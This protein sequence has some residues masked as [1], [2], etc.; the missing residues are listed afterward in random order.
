MQGFPDFQQHTFTV[1]IPLVIPEAEFFDALR[2][3]KFGS[4]LVTLY[5]FRQTVLKTVKFHGQLCR[6]AIE[7]EIVFAGEM[8]A[9][10]FE[11]RKSPGFQSKP[12]LFFF[13]RLV[14]A[15]QAG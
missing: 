7:I 6:R 4:I 2:L 12:Q 8:L 1:A 14:A 15:Q 11:P 3:Q 9:A 13:I 10:E 5:V